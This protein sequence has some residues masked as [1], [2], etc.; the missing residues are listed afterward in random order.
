[1]GQRHP[2]SCS[3]SHVRPDAGRGVSRLPRARSQPAVSCLPSNSSA[4]T[5]AMSCRPRCSARSGPRSAGWRTRWSPSSSSMR[6]D[7]NRHYEARLVRS[8][9]DQILTF[10]RDITDRKRAE[11]AASRDR[12]TLRAGIGGRRRRGLGL[13]LRDQRAVR[14]SGSEIASGVRRRRDLA[15]PRRLGIA[16]ASWRPADRDGAGEGLHRWRHRRLRSRTPDDPQG[17]QREVVPLPRIGVE[18][19][20]TARCAASSEPRWTSPNASDR[21]ISSGAHSRRRR[22]EC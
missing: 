11:A 20:T 7:G 19:R 8:G 17:R 15:P 22:R 9:P 14:R 16:S 12:A 4:G 18:S 10:V 5:C 6:L 1:M 21:P 3:G 13:E 2:A